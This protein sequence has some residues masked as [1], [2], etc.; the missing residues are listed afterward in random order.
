MPPGIRAKK[1]DNQEI[2]KYGT[3][4]GVCVSC[5]LNIFGVIMFLR[6]GWVVG[7]AGIVGA[8]LIICMA[9]LVVVLTT[10]SM[11]AIATNGKVGAGGAYYM[12]SRAVGPAI[13][14]AIGILFSM[15]MG[16]AVALYV[17]G[18]CET[19]QGN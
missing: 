2:T 1:D 7:Q 17:V 16:V 19:I 3:W 9:G 4:D 12:I 15:G 8:V 5:L 13:G 14:G 10:L 6:T 11:A 18:F